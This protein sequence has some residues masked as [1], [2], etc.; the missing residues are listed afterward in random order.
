MTVKN[1]ITLS[2]A[3]AALASQAS[4]QDYDLT[5]DAETGELTMTLYGSIINYALESSDAIFLEDEALAATNH[6]LFVSFFYFNGVPLAPVGGAVSI[7]TALGET[8]TSY[9]G[10]IGTPENPVTFSLG[11]VLPAGLTEQQYYDVPDVTARYVTSLPVA[12]QA[13]N[14]VYVPEPA[15]FV[16]LGLG[17][18]LLS[19][20]YTA[21]SLPLDS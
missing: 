21:Q 12:G 3:L 8:N 2:C 6:N 20:R 16:L 17:G 15:S 11:N 1:M 5:Y 9:N 13:F 7:P 14:L 19:R 4:A 10:P 18:V